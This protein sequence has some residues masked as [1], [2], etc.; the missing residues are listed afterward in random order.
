M[1]NEI[2]VASKY[3]LGNDEEGSRFFFSNRLLS[4]WYGHI[5]IKKSLLASEYCFINFCIIFGNDI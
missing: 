1:S 2:S 5:I 4:E 3:T